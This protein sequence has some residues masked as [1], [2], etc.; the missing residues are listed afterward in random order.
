MAKTN[1]AS[2]FDLM[3]VTILLV[4]SLFGGVVGFYVGRATAT[5]A[6]MR[7]AK[8][9]REKGALLQSMGKMMQDRGTKYQDSAMNRSGKMMLDEGSRMMG[10][11]SDVM[12]LMGQY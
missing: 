5:P 4:L 7:E 6:Y 12:G 9:L 2:K 8:T 3:N 1:Q 11:G 10:A